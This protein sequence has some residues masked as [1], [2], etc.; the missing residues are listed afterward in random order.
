MGRGKDD[1]DLSWVNHLPKED[2]QQLVAEVIRTTR[3]AAAGSLDDVVVA[4]G[5]LLTQWRTT[6]LVFRDPDLLRRLTEAVVGYSNDLEHGWRCMVCGDTD[7]PFD[8]IFVVRRP[9]PADWA[10]IIPHINVSY[11]NDRPDCVT[12]A[13]A[14]GPWPL[15]G[16]AEVPASID[17]HDDK[18][19]HGRSTTRARY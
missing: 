9:P 17:G 12:V 13:M 5:T 1:L 18:Y 14:E 16:Q 8:K 10:K 3:E 15:P 4:L 6:A 19:G 7:R 2:L 11:C